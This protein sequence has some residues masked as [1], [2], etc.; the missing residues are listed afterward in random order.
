MGFVTDLTYRVFITALNILFPPLAVL[1]IA[2]PGYD[3][4]MNCLLFLLAIL[5]S[6]IHGFYISCVYFHRKSKVLR[7]PPAPPGCVADGVGVR[8]R[9]AKATTPAAPKPSSSRRT[10]SMAARVRGKLSA[11]T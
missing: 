1:L 9:S 3:C 11:C 10:C 2:G 6:H 7:P 4:V 5:P 8:C